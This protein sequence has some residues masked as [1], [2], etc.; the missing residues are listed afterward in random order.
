[1][2]WKD[3]KKYAEIQMTIKEMELGQG[4]LQNRA[5]RA[6]RLLIRVSILKGNLDLK[7][8]IFTLEFQ[9][10]EGK[11]LLDVLARNPMVRTGPHVDVEHTDTRTKTATLGLTA[12]YKSVS[13]TATYQ[14][15]LAGSDKFVEGHGYSLVVHDTNFRLSAQ[16]EKDGRLSLTKSPSEFYYQVVIKYPGSKCGVDVKGSLNLFGASSQ[17]HVPAWR[18]IDL[19]GIERTGEDF[20]TW[21]KEK[22]EEK[23]DI[24]AFQSS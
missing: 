16:L 7:R 24:D 23:N 13:P 18:E 4:M 6:L 8:A 12:T 14:N 22:W 15:S 10:H 2:F 9:Q 17:E 3:T 19:R 11:G 21:S 1:M 20:N 5:T